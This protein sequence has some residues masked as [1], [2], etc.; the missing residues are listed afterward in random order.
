MHYFAGAK[1]GIYFKKAWEYKID[2]MNNS[3][4]VS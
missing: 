1:F 4:V 3:T 2:L